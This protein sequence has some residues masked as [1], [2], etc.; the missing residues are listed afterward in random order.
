M[1]VVGWAEEV[2]V[3]SDKALEAWLTYVSTIVCRTLPENNSLTL[4]NKQPTD[5]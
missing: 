1:E 5:A 4:K 3:G 2:A